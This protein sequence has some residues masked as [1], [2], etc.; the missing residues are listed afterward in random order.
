MQP[1]TI[2]LPD[3]THRI[4]A[5]EADERDISMSEAVREYI[6]K[7]REYDDLEAKTER[8]ERQL[9]AVNARQGDV[10]EIVEYVEEERSWRTAG[11]PRG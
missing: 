6:E 4:L 2:R 9:A 5:E 1:V 11:S 8:L 7:G 3:D 10:T